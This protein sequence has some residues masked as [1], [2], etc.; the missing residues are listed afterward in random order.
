MDRH[1]G[2]FSPED[3]EEQIAKYLSDQKLVSANT[4][5]L[6]NLQNLAEDDVHRLAEIRARLLEDT[7]SKAERA[8]L[9]LQDYQHHVTPSPRRPGPHGARQSSPLLV[10]LASGLVAILLISS[11]LFASIYFGARLARR[12]LSQQTAI[13]PSGIPSGQG[14]SAFLMDAT[15]NKV[16]VDVNSHVRKPIANLASIM[17]AVVAIE[18][19][20]PN[21][22][23]TVEQATLHAVP[24]GM[25]KAGLQAG[26]R[27]TL[28]E[29]IY[30]LLLT[31][32]DD[33]ALVI[34]QAVGGNTQQF[35][36]LMND[37]AHQLQLN[38]TS[39]AAPYSSFSPGTSSSAADLGKLANYAMQ[40]SAFS[41]MVKTQEYTL[42]ATLQRHSYQWR[43]MHNLGAADPNVNAIQIGYDARAG[44]CV[45]FSAQKH[46]HV[47]I[48]VELNAS[49][50]RDTTA[51][52][53]SVFMVP[54][55][56]RSLSGWDS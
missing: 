2:W 55:T 10:N 3:I 7:D 1:D 38:D 54:D 56:N 33:A 30:G 18:N 42:P 25:G 31:S 35:V 41:Q 21:L 9:S 53:L 39:F 49:S 43:T 14:V 19:A 28:R 50:Q 36:A 23:I 34:A 26:D 52:S 15:S 22:D 27:L 47:L 46:E 24:K 37:E 11:M 45:V 8:P 12:S 51:P 4:R 29:L 6:Q 5:M 44:A 32:G 13:P 20:D 16:L 48:G 17:T 40:L